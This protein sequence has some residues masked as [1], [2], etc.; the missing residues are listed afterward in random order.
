[1]DY[2]E[3]WSLEE[4]LKGLHCRQLLCTT[5]WANEFP[6][7]MNHI[8][9]DIGKP[10]MPYEYNKDFISNCMNQSSLSIAICVIRQKD[11]KHSNI[12]VCHFLTLNCII[13]IF[14]E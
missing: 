10:Y 14:T 7:I 9:E 4:K 3:Q 2:S 1:L 11:F 13:A 8:K 5:V 6:S 12:V